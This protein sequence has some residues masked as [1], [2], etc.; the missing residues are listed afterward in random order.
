MT[1]VVAVLMA[2]ITAKDQ[3]AI[4]A[5]TAAKKALGGEE[6]IDNIKSLILTGTSKRLYNKR[7][8]IIEIRI[9]LPDNYLW[10]EKGTTDFFDTISYN[11]FS[12]GEMRQVSFYGSERSGVARIDYK[13][14][15]NRFANLMMGA[16]LKSD[17]AAPLTIASV[18]GASDRFSIT[19]TTGEMGM[20]ELDPREKYPLLV[21]FK[22]VVSVNYTEE[23]IN[24]KNI[25]IRFLTK[26]DAVDSVIQFK[27]RTVIDGVMFPKTIIFESPGMDFNNKEVRLEKIQINPKLNLKDFDIPQ[28]P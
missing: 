9:L 28:Y 15:V 8:S 18:S 7:E 23:A 3:K 4:E 17:P 20:M 14:E 25:T 11:G 22:D 10:I 21:S 19:G 24:N 5:I 16:L 26:T 6:T 13:D 1:A 12:N 27:D 2:Q